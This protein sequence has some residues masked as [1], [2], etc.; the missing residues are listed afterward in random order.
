M[1]CVCACAWFCYGVSVTLVV[2]VSVCTRI[3]CDLLRELVSLVCLIIFVWMCLFVC[4][5][6]LCV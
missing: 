5:F 2:V 4:V 6:V 3:V 1:L